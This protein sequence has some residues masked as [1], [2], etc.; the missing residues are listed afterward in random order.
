MKASRY[1]SAIA[2]EKSSAEKCW[3]YLPHT[4]DPYHQSHI[5][6]DIP[7]KTLRHTTNSKDEIKYP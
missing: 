4:A 3:D 7:H 2:S 1:L 5:T 6:A